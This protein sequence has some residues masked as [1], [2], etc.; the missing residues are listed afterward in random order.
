[1]LAAG[2]VQLE[3]G[4]VLIEDVRLDVTFDPVT[5]GARGVFLRRVKLDILLADAAAAAGADVRTG[6][7]VTGLL[8]DGDRVVGVETDAGPI[9][10]TLVVGADGRRS[11]VARLAGAEEYQV[12]PP[13]RAFLW[14]YFERADTEPRLRIGRLGTLAFLGCPTDGGLYMAAVAPSIDD[15]D[16]F[17]ADRERNFASGLQAWPEVAEVVAGAPRVGPIRVVADWHGYF[18][19]AAGPGWVLV[20]D[21]GHFKDPTPAQGIADALRQGQRLADAIEAGLGG[22]GDLDTELTQ[23]GEWRDADAQGMQWFATTIGASGRPTPLV[24]ELMRAVADDPDATADF[25][26]VLNHDL[27]PTRL[28]G[29]RQLARAAVAAR[30][31]GASR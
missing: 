11:T 31:A 23:W 27:P 10:A 7:G 24:I 12:A 2:A 18:R 25:L 9:G 19:T 3:R 4:T 1:V 13:G 6:T 22:A 5:L 30:R 28:F 17:L 8:R 29:P 14:A 16:A 20:G 26:G 21:A 15:K